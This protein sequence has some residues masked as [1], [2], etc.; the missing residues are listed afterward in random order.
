MRIIHHDRLGR[1]GSASG[2]AHRH[3]LDGVKV[4]AV[5]RHGQDRAG[6]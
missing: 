4:D 2:D 6:R 3:P 5:R 1:P